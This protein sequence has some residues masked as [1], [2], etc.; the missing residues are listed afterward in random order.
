MLLFNFL[1]TCR[2]LYVEQE[3]WQFS[4]STDPDGVFYPQCIK[5]C[6]QNGGKLVTSPRRY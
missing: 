6:P 1:Y 4:D 5:A 3:V 2:T